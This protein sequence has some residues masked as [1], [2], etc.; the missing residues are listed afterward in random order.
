MSRRDNILV[1]PYKRL[2]GVPCGVMTASYA[3]RGVG[4]RCFEIRELL[5]AKD[6]KYQL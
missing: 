2:K 3:P 1:T 4:N 6:T 5:A